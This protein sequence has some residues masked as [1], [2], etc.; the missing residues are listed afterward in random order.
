MRY[1]LIWLLMLP[2][3]AYLELG[4]AVNK[5]HTQATAS[6]PQRFSDCLKINLDNAASE[7]ES[8]TDDNSTSACLQNYNDKYVNG[9]FN[10]NKCHCDITVNK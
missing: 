7:L 3:I 6:L 2:F 1:F 8:C 5:I 9:C 4:L 10:S